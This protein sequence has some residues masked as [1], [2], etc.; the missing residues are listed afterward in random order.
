M[1]FSS[2]GHHLL[3]SRAVILLLLLWA[4]TTAN[5]AAHALLELSLE[6][7]AIAGRAA[8]LRYNL[9]HVLQIGLVF[10][11]DAVTWEDA[12]VSN[13]LVLVVFCAFFDDGPYHH[14]LQSKMRFTVPWGLQPVWENINR[15][16]FRFTTFALYV[17]A[18]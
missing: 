2:S 8:I 9:D 5:R 3:S 18:E 6:E 10:T 4:S 1:A 12:G 17:P 11:E 14:L 13:Y 15:G 7:R 16:S